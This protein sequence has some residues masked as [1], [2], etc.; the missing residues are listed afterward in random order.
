MASKGK[1]LIGELPKIGIRPAIDGRLH[2]VRESLE[3]QTM[4]QATAVA[5]LLTANLRH[6]NGLP[7]ECVIADTCIG[8]V[9][10]AA[11]NPTAAA[12]ANA[13]YDAIGVRIKSLPITPEKILKALNTKRIE[14]VK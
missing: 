8:G 9:A 13:I 4:V 5:D 11:L 7:V 2:G 3:D 12:I 10:E 14:N 6:S 1:R